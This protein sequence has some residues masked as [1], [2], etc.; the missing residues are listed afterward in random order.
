MKVAQT[1][2]THPRHIKAFM[3]RCLK[4]VLTDQTVQHHANGY[5]ADIVT[6]R[7]VGNIGTLP[8][9]EKPGQ[10]LLLNTGINLLDA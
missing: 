3:G 6:R 9:Q 8:R 7:H 2:L 5:L 10:Y 1:L 4:D